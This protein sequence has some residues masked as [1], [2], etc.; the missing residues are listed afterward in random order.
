MFSSSKSA[1]SS[2]LSKHGYAL[3]VIIAVLFV[4]VTLDQSADLAGNVLAMVGLPTEIKQVHDNEGNTCRH[5]PMLLTVV[6]GIL[7]G[8]LTVAAL[9]YWTK[10][11]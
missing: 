9:N 5:V 3:V 4:V 2:F 11:K 1:R 8:L 7:L 6:G 10:S